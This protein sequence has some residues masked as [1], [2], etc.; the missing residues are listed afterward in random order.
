[1]CGELVVPARPRNQVLARPSSK[2]S[3]SEREVGALLR[4]QLSPYLLERLL[5]LGAKAVALRILIRFVQQLLALLVAHHL[6]MHVVAPYKER[7]RNQHHARACTRGVDVVKQT[8][9]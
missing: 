6:S 7:D 9:T 1:M 5:G 8:R 4:H 2:A 3:E